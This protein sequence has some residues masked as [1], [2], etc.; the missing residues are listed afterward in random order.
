MKYWRGCCRSNQVPAI[1]TP[2]LVRQAER[3]WQHLDPYFQAGT[4]EELFNIIEKLGPL[5]EDSLVRRCKVD[6]ADWLDELKAAN[7]IILSAQD[8]RKKIQARVAHQSNQTGG[9]RR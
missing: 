5:A 4:A 2:E 6:P 1:L 9:F 3:R 7:R 8:C